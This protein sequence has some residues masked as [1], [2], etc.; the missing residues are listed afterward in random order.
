M[1][2]AH[3]MLKCTILN[4]NLHLFTKFGHNDVLYVYFYWWIL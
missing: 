2:T 1:L 4:V 3:R